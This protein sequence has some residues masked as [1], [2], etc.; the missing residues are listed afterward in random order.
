MAQTTM[1]IRVDT[2]DKKRFEN[3]CNQT[4]MNVS[5]A[6]NMF[7]KAVLRED[8]LPFEI[9]TDPFYNDLN[10]S[11]LKDS[12]EQIKRGKTVTKSLDELKEMEN[13]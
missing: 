10:M 7:I 5:V 2:E 1:S 4:G 11:I 13:E 9:K 12:I 3:F 8:R 6:V